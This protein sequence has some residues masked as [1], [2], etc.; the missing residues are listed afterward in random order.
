MYILNILSILNILI[1]LL[2]TKLMEKISDAKEYHEN[3]TKMK[4]KKAMK[5]S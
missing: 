4:I 5:L 1:L 3:F 2:A